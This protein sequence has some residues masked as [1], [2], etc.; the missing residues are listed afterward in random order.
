[1]NDELRLKSRFSRVGRTEEGWAFGYLW[2]S[3]RRCERDQ[4]QRR[5][6]SPS[7]IVYSF[8]LGRGAAARDEAR[9]L[10]CSARLDQIQRP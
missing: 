5:D 2:R 8:V 4:D 6:R 9:E 10:L 1:M 3:G 7:R